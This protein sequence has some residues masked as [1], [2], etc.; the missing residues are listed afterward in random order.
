MA[1]R[2]FVGNL[3]RNVTE[4]ELKEHFSPAGMLSFISIP[5]DR[6]T[7]RH[8]GF[9]F[10]E[11]RDRAEAEAAIRS[12]NNKSFK[13][14]PLSVTEARPRE[15]R[16]APRPAPAGQ[17]DVD[18]SPARKPNSNFG[19]DASPQRGRAKPRGKA[20]P[21]RAPK[22]PMREVVRGQFFGDPDDEFDEY[23]DEDDNIETGQDSMPD[24][25]TESDDVVGVEKS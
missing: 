7:G 24:S 22:G 10:L 5:L 3:P 8:R 23:D 21:E 25:M 17:G 16:T 6:E 18:N 14:N 19:P 13:G 15:D 2:L 12:F 4:A 11:F 9:A 20:G 1:I